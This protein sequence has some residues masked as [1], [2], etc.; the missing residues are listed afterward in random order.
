[1]LVEKSLGTPKPFIGSF[2]FN[3]NQFW[4]FTSTKKLKIA[5]SSSFFNSPFLCLLSAERNN[6]VPCFAAAAALPFH[7][8]PLLLHN[9]IIFFFFTLPPPPPEKNQ[10][11]RRRRPVVVDASQEFELAPFHSVVV[12]K[13]A[14]KMPPEL[15][16]NDVQ[17]NLEDSRTIWFRFCGHRFSSRLRKCELEWSAEIEKGC[18]FFATFEFHRMPDCANLFLRRTSKQCERW[19]SHLQ[20]SSLG[21]TFLKNKIALARW[22]SL[23][24]VVHGT[25][26]RILA[27]ANLCECAFLLG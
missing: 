21:K 19:V 17:W 7:F 12:E 10:R 9:F 20:E 24:N 3:G 11:R 26:V 13:R 5:L 6:R 1:M 22:L 8:S 14:K 18:F 27:V 4:L 23:L 16:F 2:H 15:F 25:R